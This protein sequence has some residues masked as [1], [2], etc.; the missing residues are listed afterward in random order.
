MINRID[1]KEKILIVDDTEDTVELLRKRFRADG[2]DTDEAFDGEE[3]LRKVFEYRPNLV[4]LDVMMPK[5]DGYQ[6]C[7]KLKKDETTK[8]MPVLML[9]AKS[10]IG[11]KIKGLDIGADDYIGKPFDYKEVVARVRSLLAKK[12]VSKKM[13]EKEKSEA[14]D[15]LV[16]EVSHEVRNPLVAIGGF[17]RRVYKNLP[18]D[19]ENRKYLQVI[20]QNVAIL[21]KMVTELVELKGANV[22]YFEPVDI[23]EILRSTLAIFAPEIKEQNIFVSTNLMESPPLVQADSENISQ[24]IFNIIENGIEA[25]D[26]SPHQL[27]VA[28][29]VREGFVEIEIADN[30]CGIDRE[31]LKSIY[32]PFFTSKTRGPGLG[33]TFALKTVQNHNGFISVNSIKG[34]GTTFT[35]HLPIH[36]AV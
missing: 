20:L 33:L 6:V 7:E 36:A 23:N 32:D 24:A 1:S 27:A 26:E 35:I 10:E 5:L 25:L 12:D 21:E 18:E 4:V 15:H 19:D 34:E 31:T 8:H 28:S 22:C 9:T 3:G 11:D 14:L 13:A 16:D 30:G 29:S 17:A 2:Y